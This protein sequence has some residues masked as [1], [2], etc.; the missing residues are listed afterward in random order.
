MQ[1]AGAVYHVF[2]RGDRK[3]PIFLADDDRKLFLDT[4]AETCVRSGFRIHGYGL[5]DNHYHLE[6]ETPEPNLVDGMR[7]FQGTYTQRFNR[8]HDLV[9]HLYQG[10]YKAKPID[11]DDPNYFRRVAEY[12]HL[13]AACAGLLDREQPD[14]ITYPWSSFGYFVRK[15]RHLSD[16]LTP[17]RVFQSFGLQDD[18]VGRQAF[19]DYMNRRALEVTQDPISFERQNQWNRLLQG[20][21]EG[22]ERFREWLLDRMDALRDQKKQDAQDAG[23]LRRHDQGRAEELLRLGATAAGLP[24]ESVQQ[25]PHNHPIKQGLAWLVKTHTTMTERWTIRQLG[26]GHRSNV[27]RAV[28]AYLEPEDPQ[29]RAFKRTCLGCLSAE[30]GD[31]G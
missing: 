20:W 26:M 4:L 1:Y 31:A 11:P 28:A 6:L 3:E 14:L 10:R 25:L 2:D 8:R 18:R 12:I 16:W 30:G 27:G 21:Y 19:R 24:L 17:V 9:G 22:S 13:N 5:M 7:W 29:R 23:T 15:R